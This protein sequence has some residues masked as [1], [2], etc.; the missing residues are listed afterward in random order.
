[1]SALSGCLH[2]QHLGRRKV[3][4]VN[5]YA[6]TVS[7]LSLNIWL[8]FHT[9]TVLV[10]LLF[11]G[12]T[13]LALFLIF[14]NYGLLLIRYIFRSSILKNWQFI[15]VHLFLV[16]HE[17]YIICL[18][19]DVFPSLYLNLGSLVLMGVFLIHLAVHFCL[20]AGLLLKT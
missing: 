4:K 13:Y 3:H 15:F 2:S 10:S 1:M 6:D 8:P 12:W 11:I 17:R 20:Q 18:H 9:E 19:G 14:A 5:D 16:P 7:A